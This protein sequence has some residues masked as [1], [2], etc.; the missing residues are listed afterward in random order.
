MQARVSTLRQVSGAAFAL[1]LSLT[2]MSAHAQFG[3]L[4]QSVINSAVQQSA[5]QAAQQAVTNA[6]VTAATG[7]P[8]T[9]LTPQQTNAIAQAAV[10]IPAND[11]EYQALLLQGL[12]SVPPAQRNAYAPIIDLQ[13]R[14]TLAARRMGYTLPAGGL[15]QVATGTNPLANA[16][17]QN[18]IVQ[19]GVNPAAL[20]TDAGKAVA[21]GAILQGLGSLFGS[22]PAATQE[23]ASA[24]QP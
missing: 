12:A 15:S 24:S 3:G 17:V 6:A 22:R 5:Q 11:P 14:Q 1:A 23:A 8:V 19:G 21:A 16:A 18:A 9:S 13:V 4:F 20:S 10:A 2:A 7:Q